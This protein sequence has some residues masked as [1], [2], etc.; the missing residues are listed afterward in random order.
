MK[1]LNLGVNNHSF[2]WRKIRV[3]HYFWREKV[4]LFWRSGNRSY[5]LRVLGSHFQVSNGASGQNQ[6]TEPQ[7]DFYRNSVIYILQVA[8]CRAYAEF[9]NLCAKQWRRQTLKSGGAQLHY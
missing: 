6:A 1:G 9:L 4:I 3:C 2:S 5:C 7:G 8:Y